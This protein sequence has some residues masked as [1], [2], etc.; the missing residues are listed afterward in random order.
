MRPFAL[1]AIGKP[2]VLM[3]AIDAMCVG[4]HG[5]ARIDYRRKHD[6]FSQPTGARRSLP[7]MVVNVNNTSNIPP[8]K[9]ETADL[10]SERHRVCLAM[11][12]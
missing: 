2:D 12:T 7:A 6:P 1:D 9:I 8:G 3:W 10:I 11:A 5:A 4:C